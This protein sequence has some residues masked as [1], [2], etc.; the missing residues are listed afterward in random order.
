[1]RKKVA[2]ILLFEKDYSYLKTTLM[3][4]SIRLHDPSKK[5]T[6]IEQLLHENPKIED[7]AVDLVV[8]LA[9]LN[10]TPTID[11]ATF[12]YKKWDALYQKNAQHAEAGK[13]KR[14]IPLLPQF[15]AEDYSSASDGESL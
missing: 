5:E 7:L 15:Q 2:V 12:I 4:T 3:R 10:T 13:K 1:M 8:E 11:I 9:K 6:L 14:K